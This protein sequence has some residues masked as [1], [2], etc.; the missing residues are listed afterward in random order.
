MS[1][2]I[3]AAAENAR[4]LLDTR[5]APEPTL[6]QD[7]ISAERYTSREFMAREWDH[8]WTRVW[9]IAGLESEVA[10]PGAFVVSQLGRE[11]VIV[12]RDEQGELRGFYNV[13]QHR[14]NRLLQKPSGRVKS[15]RCPYH[16]WV[17]SPGGELLAVQDAED[18]PRGNPCGK[19]S[20][21]PVRVASALGFVWFNLDADAQ[22]LSDFL[23]PVGEQIDTYQMERM[24]RTHHIT[25][26]ADCNWKVIQD[27]FNESYHIPTVHPALKYFLDDT[28]Q[29]TQ[30]DL[31]PSGHN[32]ML[33]LGGGPSPR[34]DKEEET[35]LRF[36]AGE[37][38]FWGL[39][40]EDFRGRVHEIRG[41][42]QQ[43]KRQLGA[44]KG[45]DFSRVID[46]QL[47]DHLHYTLFPNISLSLK[48]DGCIFLRG[49]PHPSDPEKCFFDVWYFTLFPEGQNEYF[50]SS[51]ADAV[52]R[53]AK[54][55]HQTGRLGD[56]FLGGG[57]DQDAS[58]FLSQ[59]QGLR[60]RGYQG[61]YLS[62]Q[63]RRVQYYHQVIDEYISGKR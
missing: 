14:G 52:E 61:V 6:S 12:T 22:P 60:S 18:F 54:V 21:A 7:P 62:G 30:F 50:A 11:S 38:E 44:E 2:S 32:R 5:K 24:V 63:E 13:C 20:L 17:W 8:M 46:A 47:T 42:L 31:Y 59:Q 4:G 57:L 3:Q 27:N 39:A 23:A 36:M 15:F 34:A 33:M 29:N 1:S 49:T 28:Y 41:A 55:E 40:A 56:I 53:D 16:G 35:A 51:M 58:V 37:L 45:F 25:L 26:E 43:Q 48:P 9:N 19:L 10:S